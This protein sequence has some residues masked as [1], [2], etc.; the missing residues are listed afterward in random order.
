MPAAIQK[1]GRH[2]WNEA[3]SA[4]IAGG[5]DRAEMH[6]FMII[7]A[8]QLGRRISQERGGRG[9]GS[10]QQAGAPSLEHVPGE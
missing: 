2:A 5:R 9:L 8:A 10:W 4:A 7:A 6:I 3:L 1:S